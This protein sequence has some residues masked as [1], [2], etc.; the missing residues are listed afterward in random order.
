MSNRDP[1]LNELNRQVTAA[2]FRA[3]HLPAGPERERAFLVVGQLEEAIAVI[4]PEGST[5]G[6]VAKLGAVMAAMS[7]GRPDRAI[8]LANRWPDVPGMSGLLDEATA[9]GVQ[10]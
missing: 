6:N 8:L 1:R 7:A 2:I 3:E 5:Q 9:M 4:C 10:P